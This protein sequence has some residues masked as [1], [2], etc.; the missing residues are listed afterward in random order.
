VN[1]LIQPSPAERR[2][3]QEGR[4]AGPMTWVIAIMM[5]LTILA[6]VGGLAVAESARAMR[7]DLAGKITVQIAEANPVLRETQTRQLVREIGSLSIV[8]RVEAIPQDALV[9]M[10]EPWLGE[11][12]FEADLPIPALIDVELR[13][14]A[15]GAT[16]AVSRVVK[17]IVPGAS[18]TEQQEWLAPLA[19]LLAALK[20]LAAALVV[21]V[22]IATAATVV[23]AVRSSL[24]THRSTIDVLHLLGASDRQVATL[25]QRR[26]ALD[27]LFG[28]AAGLMIA[29]LVV[30][31]IA[32]RVAAL[33]SGL[34]GSA[35]LG[36]T[37]WA[38]IV[39]IPLIGV[40][41]ATLSARI[42]VLRALRRTL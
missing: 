8:E 14:A 34:A 42:T 29:L 23:L 17:A 32:R 19:A 16:Q 13:E 31:L 5:F 1:S 27:A 7:E 4:L 41:L 18:V 11:K 36:W 38:I 21:L 20:W 12:G 35:A 40:A 10:L 37:D 9:D 28:G 22:G 26:I 39:T 25:F 33:G 2:L 15:P 24:N 3:L 30:A 6:A